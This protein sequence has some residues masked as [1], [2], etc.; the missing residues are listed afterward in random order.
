MFFY[1]S[2]LL[3][4]LGSNSISFRRYD[5]IAFIGIDRPAKRNALDEVTLNRLKDAVVNFENDDALT[6]GV[7]HGEGGSFCSGLDLKELSESDSLPKTFIRNVIFVYLKYSVI[8]RHIQG[9][10]SNPHADIL[11]PGHWHVALDPPVFNHNGLF[12]KIISLPAT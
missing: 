4:V 6:I 11:Q 10:T 2:S 12:K 9:C 3:I 5:E 7:I 8:I 1:L